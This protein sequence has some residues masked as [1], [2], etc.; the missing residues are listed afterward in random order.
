MAIDSNTLE[1]ISPFG[2]FESP[3][4]FELTCKHDGEEI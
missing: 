2:V 3:G 4:Q 1:E